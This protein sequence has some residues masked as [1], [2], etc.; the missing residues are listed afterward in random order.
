MVYGPTGT[1]AAAQAALVVGD[2]VEL[3]G[4]HLDERSDMVASVEP[5]PFRNNTG[6]PWPARS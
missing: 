5:D 1:A 4:E 6:G 2:H 3:T